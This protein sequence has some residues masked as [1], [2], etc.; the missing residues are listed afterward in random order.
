M[1]WIKKKRKRKSMKI[2]LTRFTADNW[3]TEGDVKHPLTLD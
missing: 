2:V 1:Y 3:P